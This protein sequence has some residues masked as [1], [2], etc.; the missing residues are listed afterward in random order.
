MSSPDENKLYFTKN[1]QMHIVILAL[2]VFK[3]WKN[4]RDQEFRLEEFS[5]RKL[6]ENHFKDVES[7][8]S[9]QLIISRSKSTCVISSSS[10]TRRIAKPRQKFAATCMEYAWYIRKRFWI[11]YMRVLRQLIQECSIQGIPLLREMFQCKQVRRNP[12][13]KVVIETTTNLEP[14]WLKS[15]TVSQ[16]SVLILILEETIDRNSN[17][18]P[19]GVY[20]KKRRVKKSQVSAKC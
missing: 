6:V 7:V 5:I 9:G 3:S 14:K 18:L 10:W 19:E 17:A 13:Q 15:L 20:L 1:W 12:K 8:R 16:F 11:V 2:E 4:W